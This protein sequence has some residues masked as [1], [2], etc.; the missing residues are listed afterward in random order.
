[1]SLDLVAIVEAPL[2][3]LLFFALLLVCRGLPALLV[4]RGALAWRQRAQTALVSA[5]A[6]PTLVALTEIG[7]RNGT[8]LRENAASLV[9]A[10]VLTVLLLP[11]LAVALHRPQGTASLDS[12]RD[13][14][15]PHSVP[16]E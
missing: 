9:G 4:Y 2:R 15:G 1:M 16:T 3:L 8:M 13:V 10:G 12:S 11:G 7:L 6:L 5:T 14:G